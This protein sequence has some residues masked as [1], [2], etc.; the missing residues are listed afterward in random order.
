MNT[1]TTTFYDDLAPFYHL[2]Y[3]DWK[4][5]VDAQGRAL[6]E[7]LQALEIP[8]GAVVLDA[9]C[10]IGTQALGLLQQGYRM[11]ASDLSPGAVERLGQ[12]A[13]RR[14]LRLE[15]RVDDLRTLAGHAGPPLDAVIACDNSLPHLLS[16]AEI[17]QA[18]RSCHRCLRPGGVA[19]F[20]VRDYAVIERK[21]PDVRPYGLRREGASRFLAVQ[22]WEW[23]G[24]QY[25]VR[26]Y[27]TSESGEGRC[28]TRVLKSR[29]YA[30]TVDRLADLMRTAGFV[31]VARRDDVLFQPVLTGRRPPAP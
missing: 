17:L 25:E 27:L 7:L 11:T 15:A 13:S 20:S 21:S 6:A 9:A 1:D 31:D 8:S 19:V 22:V 10:G 14:G 28:E 12:E 2:L 4:A 23:E 29:Y 24:D 5:S 3:A 30:I 26:M 16:D 18:L